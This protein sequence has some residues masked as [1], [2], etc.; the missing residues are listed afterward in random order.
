MNTN[1][2]YF[3]L[4]LDNRN[5]KYYSKSMISPFFSEV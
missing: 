5:K 4:A 3:K 1:I 2:I